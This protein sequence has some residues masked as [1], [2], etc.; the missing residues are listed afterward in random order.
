MRLAILGLC[1]AA[2]LSRP[3]PSGV[4]IDYEYEMTLDKSK[5][6]HTFL[7]WAACEYFK[8]R[9]G[10]EMSAY[11]FRALNHVQSCDIVLFIG[12]SDSWQNFNYGADL[13]RVTG[14]KK[15]VSIMEMACPG[16]DASYVFLEGQPG[17]FFQAPA[18]KSLYKNIE[19]RPKTL[20]LD[21]PWLPWTPS[22]P[23][24]EWTI[25]IQEWLRP[26][27]GWEK[28]H[29][30]EKHT[31]HFLA[32]GETFIEYSAF[33]QYIEATDRI[34]NFI[35]SHSG[36]YEFSIIDF[37]ARGIRVIAPWCMD[38]TLTRHFDVPRFRNQQDLLKI[39]NTPV[40]TNYWNHQID[41]CTDYQEIFNAMEE[42]FRGWM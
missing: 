5:S 39:L 36:S 22:R 7:T 32:P 1:C 8:N 14:C 4:G 18:W 3:H 11:D 21:H 28:Y 37:A 6:S 10:I 19:K 34:E 35:L 20:L 17:N 33:P 12:Y 2:H 38:N 25:K 24:I 42:D 15:I 23:D 9:P 31:K 16:A 30:L 29:L 40:D 13:R 41:R 27:T 26:L